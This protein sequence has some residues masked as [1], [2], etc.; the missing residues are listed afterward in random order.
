IAGGYPLPD[1]NSLR[2]GQRAL[3]LA[4]SVAPDEVVVFLV[5]GGGSAVMEWPIDGMASLEEMRQLYRALV[6]CGA[7]IVTVNTIRKHL[8]AVKAGR[9][10]LAAGRACAHVTILLSDVPDR[11]EAEVASGPSC[12]DRTTTTDCRRALD[13][14]GLWPHIPPRLADRLRRDDLPPRF[15]P[16]TVGNGVPMIVEYD[17]IGSNETAR[18]SAAHALRSLGVHSLDDV[19]SDDWQYERAAAHLLRRLERL[20]RRWPSRRVAVVSGGELSVPLPPNPGTG[21]RNQQFVL[22]CA[23]LIRGQPITVLSAGT[24]GVDGNSP[25][26]G[27]LADGTTMARA[28][29]LGLD[30][31]DALARCDAFPLLH[32]LGDTIVTGPTGTNVRDLRL[33]VHAG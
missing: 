32:A 8:S 30:V 19:A 25:A 15:T 11:L 21:G 20:R 3:E 27:A 6:A 23:R 29:A 5:S 16:D 22:A 7:D 28:R 24:D 17:E 18:A 12:I 26:A 13:N 33:L 10:A 4:R 9:L 1:A 31:H 2:A 14:L